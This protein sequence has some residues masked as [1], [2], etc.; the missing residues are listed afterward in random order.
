VNNA[1]KQL[2]PGFFANTDQ[3][4][5]E[6]VV[7]R[8]I[9]DLSKIFPEIKPLAECIVEPTAKKM[10]FDEEKITEKLIKRYGD[11]F[12]KMAKDIKINYL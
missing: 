6:P 2:N 7:E 3:P 10:K 8:P 12:Q 9:A 5:D 4:E 1:T 11:N